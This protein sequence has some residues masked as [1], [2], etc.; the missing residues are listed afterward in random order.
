MGNDAN[1][2]AV[3]DLLHNKDPKIVWIQVNSNNKAESILL[4][5][6]ETEDPN[7]YH[8]FSYLNRLANTALFHKQYDQLKAIADEMLQS[9][10]GELDYGDMMF[11]GNVFNGIVALKRD[12]NLENAKQFLLAAGQTPGSAVL[13]SFGPNMSLAKDLL[14]L[15]EQQVVLKYFELCRKFWTHHPETLDEW[16]TIVK[17]GQIPDFMANLSY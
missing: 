17:Q 13:S 4:N 2:E 14:E 7:N 8:R 9:K 16:E 15:G 11:K 6:P 3:A 10:P 12:N 1:D 5:K